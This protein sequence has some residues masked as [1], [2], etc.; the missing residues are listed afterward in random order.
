MTTEAPNKGGRPSFPEADRLSWTCKLSL[1][2]HIGE[3]VER[4]AEAGGIR[5]TK[6]VR[7]V[8]EGHIAGSASE[9]P[10][11]RI[12]ELER[13]IAEV[14]AVSSARIADLEEALAPFARIGSTPGVARMRG[15]IGVISAPTGK[16][17]EDGTVH[18]YRLTADKLHAA[19]VALVI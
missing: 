7:R 12:A 3:A 6:Y 15:S 13:E 18:V 4:L 14:L 10:G 16:V 17:D 9:D 11:A 8:M 1:R 19:V 5:V 2:P